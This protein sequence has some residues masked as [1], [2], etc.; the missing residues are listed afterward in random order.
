MT[1]AVL[2][3][4]YKAIMPHLNERQKRLLVAAEA[5][6]FGYGGGAKVYKCSGV[7]RSTIYRGMKDLEAE[8]KLGK[9]KSRRAGGGQK[10]LEV[11]Q[12]GI[13][14]DLNKLVDPESRGDPESP[15]KWTLKSTREIEGEL[16]KHG[17]KISHNK[18]GQ[19]LKHKLGYSLQGNV[20]AKEGKTH[21]DRDEQF[22]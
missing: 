14:E 20:K 8:T 21:E 7:A 2:K 1:E 9:S 22:K 4:K 5:Q 6:S 12:P 18:V 3:K 16:K 17:Y 15:L 13:V 11:K 10:K 19:V